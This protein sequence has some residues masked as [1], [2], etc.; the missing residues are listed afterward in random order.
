[1]RPPTTASRGCYRS[2]CSAPPAARVHLR[3]AHGLVAA[4][5]VLLLAVTLAACGPGGVRP[6]E[7][8]VAPPGMNGQRVSTTWLRPG[9]G[10]PILASPETQDVAI[11]ERIG[12]WMGYWDTRA[13]ARFGRALVRMG[14]YEQFVDS[15]LAARRLPASLRYLPIIEASYNPTAESRVGAAGLWQFMPRTARW[16]GL[17]VDD[18]VDERLDPFAA[19]PRA[20]DYLER[21]NAQFPSWFL[22]LAAY[23]AGPGRVGRAIRASGGGD[24]RDDVLFLKIRDRLPP[25]TRDFLPKY[26]AAAIIAG[27]PASFGF[28]ALA[29][30][31]RWLFDEASVV[32]AAS[33]EAIA[34]AAGVPVA[35]VERLNPHLRLGLTPADA[36]T[37]LRLPLGSGAGFADRFAAIPPSAR[38]ARSVHTVAPGETLW[39]I[40]RHYRLSLEELRNANP[41]VEPKRLQVGTRLVI[42][43]REGVYANPPPKGD[44]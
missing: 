43:G 3:A 38:V 41:T 29:K 33:V 31:R 24:V 5:P 9:H 2:G 22:T 1:M 27:D 16:M 34:E 35:E 4:L 37:L 11:Q 40:A 8:G 32:V 39:E 25:Q 42:P 14:R 18:L 13:R 21:L 28:A 6:P 36:S 7:A 30:D 10:D 19:T 26:L 15:L 44:R 23:N 17:R 20:L 12:W